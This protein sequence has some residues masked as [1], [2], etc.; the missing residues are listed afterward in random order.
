MR[1]RSPSRCSSACRCAGRRAEEAERR[2]AT[3][4]PL[5]LKTYPQAT[6]K[7][8]LASVLKA[9]EAKR[10]DYLVAQL[11]DPAYI[12]DRVQRL[13]GG[14]FQPNRSR[15]RALDDRSPARSSCSSAS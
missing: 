3:A 4:S 10:I 1:A 6:A 11:A 14:K 9:V 5:D 15:T 13:Y 2:R 7:E 12:D 8:A